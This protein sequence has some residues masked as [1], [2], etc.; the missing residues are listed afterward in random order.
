MK[1]LLQVLRLFL[2]LVFL[3]L[4]LLILNEHDKG[5]LDMV[6]S[7]GQGLAVVVLD[8]DD[9]DEAYWNRV[10]ELSDLSRAYGKSFHI[11]NVERADEGTLRS[12]MPSNGGVVFF[13]DGAIGSRFP[14]RRIFDKKIDAI[15]AGDTDIA[16]TDNAVRNRVVLTGLFGIILLL[17]L[18]VHHI[19][20]RRKLSE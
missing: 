12:I 9:L 18:T 19:T 4:C 13:S 6:E 15:L 20:R 16:V 11:L 1:Y 5:E 14:R 2:L 17:T 10:S 7:S 8:A 3:S